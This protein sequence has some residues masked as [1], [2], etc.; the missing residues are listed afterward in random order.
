VEHKQ[1]V[2]RQLPVVAVL[3]TVGEA[4]PPLP[5]DLTDASAEHWNRIFSAH[6]VSPTYDVVAV[7]RLCQMYEQRKLMQASISEHGWMLWRSNGSPMA[8]PMIGQL[9]RLDTEIRQLE[10]EFGLTPAARS[11][12]GLTEVQRQSKLDEMIRRQR[13]A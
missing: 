6:W 11:R 3:P 1:R 2:G 4:I 5:A 10:T 9:N 7:T 13:D 12:L 8:N